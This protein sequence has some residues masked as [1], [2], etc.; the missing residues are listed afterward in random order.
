MKKPE[1][2]KI[3]KTLIL[4][5]VVVIVTLFIG[6]VFIVIPFLSKNKAFRADILHERDRNILIGTVRALDKHLKVYEKRL[7][8]GRGVSWLLSQ[9]SD[10]ASE[11]G[12]DISSIKPGTPEKRGLYTKLYVE[13]DI[14]S[15]YHQLGRFISKVESSEKFLRVERINTKR[16]DENADFEAGDSKVKAFDTKSHIVISMVV[17]K[18]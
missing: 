14:G 8:K 16:L 13:M 12:I 15:T 4:T 9:V 17:L 10:M 3:S 5:A 11:E 2:K 1:T 6:V 7:P 18:E